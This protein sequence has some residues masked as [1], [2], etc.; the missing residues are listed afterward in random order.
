MAWRNPGFGTVHAEL[1]DSGAAWSIVTAAGAGST[2]GSGSDGVLNGKLASL[3]D[4]RAGSMLEWDDA[5]YLRLDRGASPGNTPDTLYIP[6][7]HNLTDLTVYERTTPTGSTT[8]VGS[9]S[10]LSPSDPVLV[11]LS[12]IERYL[13]IAP[14]T[15]GGVN[16]RIGEAI[17][18]AMQTP[19]IGPEPEWADPLEPAAQRVTF[20]S[21][22]SALLEKGAGARILELAYPRV[23]VAGDRTILAAVEAT[24]GRPLVLL[25]PYDAETARWVYL[26]R[27]AQRREDSGLPRAWA[28]L[29]PAYTLTLRDHVL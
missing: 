8:S 28:E 3:S 14:T 25:P 13:D 21:G 18:T 11:T 22:A 19:T 4:L 24:K 6:P 23:D 5:E 16:A 20:D 17:Y 12:S 15:S 27:D 1:D 7:G 9:A 29:V 26:E 10:G 2:Q